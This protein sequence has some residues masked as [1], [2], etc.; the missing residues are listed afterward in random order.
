[1]P[2]H[3]GADTKSTLSFVLNNINTMASPITKQPFRGIYVALAI[4][5]EAAR[6][7]Y[8]ILHYASS[9]GRPVENWTFQQ[10]L[11]ARIVKANCTTWPPS[12]SALP[13]I[14]DRERRV[15]ASSPSRRPTHLS[16]HDLWPTPL[17]SRLAQSA[18]P[19]RR[20]RSL[21]STIRRNCTLCCTCTV[22]RMLSATAVMETQAFS[23]EHWSHIARLRMY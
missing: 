3:I 4:A 9:S 19:G 11:R 2:I 6:F 20:L 5:L 23:L 7:P 10:A 21:P 14:S 17:P 18:Q 8:W 13:R 1:M 16:T 15:H 12:K 22:E